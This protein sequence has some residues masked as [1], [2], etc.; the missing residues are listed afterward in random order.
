MAKVRLMGLMLFITSGLLALAAI[1]TKTTHIRFK[2]PDAV[3][4]GSV[5][6]TEARELNGEVPVPSSVQFRSVPIVYPLS[7]VGGLGLLMWFVP[8]AGASTSTTGRNRTARRR[9]RRRR[10]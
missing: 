7:G 2:Q 4:A 6:P 9:R 3:E 10:K 5:D 8:A 1:A